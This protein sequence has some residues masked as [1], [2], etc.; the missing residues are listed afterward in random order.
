MATFS[1]I[2]LNPAG[3]EMTGRIQAVDVN[4]ARLLVRG[5]G[6]R[7]LD[8]H[9]GELESRTLLDAVKAFARLLHGA[10]GVRNTDLMLFYRQMQ[11]MLRAGHTILEALEAAGRLA[12]RPRLSRQLAR[13][14]ERISAGSSFSAAL[15]RE[16]STFPRIAVKLAE[17]GESSGELDAVFERLAVL[18]ER[19]TD[20]R[21]QLMTAL[22]YPSIVLLVSIGVISF[23]VGTVVPRFALFLQSRGKSIPWAAQTMLDVADWLSRWGALL[24]F[25][26]AGTIGGFIVLHR[27][28]AARLQIDRLLLHLPVVGSTLMAAAMAQISWTFGLLLKSRL[29]V[30]E[31]LRSVAQITG[32]AALTRALEQAADMVI[33]GRALTVALD[34]APIP[35]LVRHMAAIGERS[36]EMET[37]LEA[38]G[39]HYQKELDARVK[40]LSA[41]IE[42]VL[43]LFIG[44]IVGFVY[45]A[46]FQ[47][48]L[49]VSTGGG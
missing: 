21:R 36:G 49:A 48:V 10:L 45:Y 9:Q 42:P 46:F 15:S 31:A 27:L 47:A 3:K 44:G 29:T 1:Y 13:C 20:I 25:A 14:A 5:L 8:L 22:T 39:N 37:V 40:I 11:L 16:S 18:T 24:G 43:T 2:A 12:S 28:P 17:A 6:L 38:L 30:L 26:I 23:L 4:E 32:N 35:P 19:R 41:L 33:E 7:I 34:R